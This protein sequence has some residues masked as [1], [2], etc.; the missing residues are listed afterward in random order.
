MTSLQPH[1]DDRG[2]FIEW[3]QKDPLL[4]ATGR[5][6]PL[7]QA[8]VSVSR[9]G[10]LRG[11]HFVD[12]PDGQAKWVSCVAGRVLDVVVDVRVGSPTYGQFD[13]VMLGEGEWRAV[14]MAEGLGHA[15]M[16]LTESAV[17]AYLCSAR[18]VAGRERSVNPLDPDLALP[19][20]D[21]VERIVSAKDTAAPTLAEAEELGILPR[22]AD[23]VRLGATT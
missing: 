7:A 14:Y 16:A 15:F 19:W 2:K 5:A 6:L 21:D 22:Y 10:V 11:V 4:A 3:F 9:R 1:H 23:C 12:V 13:A 8:N 20:P 17:V 18:Y